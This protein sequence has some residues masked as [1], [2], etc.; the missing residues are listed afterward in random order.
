MKMKKMLV[1]AV[2]TA[3]AAV[4]ICATS[5]FAD[6]PTQWTYTYEDAVKPSMTSGMYVTNKNG[7]TPLSGRYFLHAMIPPKAAGTDGIVGNQ[8][9]IS[10]PMKLE[11]GKEYKLSFWY[12]ETGNGNPYWNNVRIA[13]KNNVANR[14][15]GENNFYNGGES[16][17]WA[18]KK[19]GDTTWTK[20]E[21]TF[22]YDSSKTEEPCIYFLFRATYNESGVAEYFIDDCS[23]V[24]KDDPT[25]TNLLPNG[26]FETPSWEGAWSAYS[27]NGKH[28]ED[29]NL[30]VNSD[31]NYVSKGQKSIYFKYPGAY[32]N[33]DE[34]VLY[35]EKPISL[36]KD[37]T[38]TLSFYIASNDS[39]E[40]NFGAS[41][42][43]FNGARL[44]KID[45]CF[46]WSTYKAGYTG[47]DQIPE[48]AFLWKQQD[49]ET[50]GTNYVKYT[51]TPKDNFDDLH[52]CIELIRSAWGTGRP[53]A[54]QNLYI[55][56]VR[57]AET[58]S[59]LNMLDDGSFEE[60]PGSDY[61][62]YQYIGT[63]EGSKIELVEAKDDGSK[64]WGEN[65]KILRMEYP[66][67]GTGKMRVWSKPIQ[68]LEDGKTYTLTFDYDENGGNNHWDYETVGLMN[69][70]DTLPLVPKY[71][72]GPEGRPVAQGSIQA[73]RQFQYSNGWTFTYHKLS[74]DAPRIYYE[75]SGPSWD[76]ATVVYLDNF[77]LCEEG[78]TKNLIKD[79][80]FEG[81]VGKVEAYDA[82]ISG[83]GVSE[84][85][86]T[87]KG[88]VTVSAKASNSTAQSK[89]VTVIAA[90][91]HGDKLIDVS[92]HTETVNALEDDKTI[93]TDI[94]ISELDDSSEYVL[95]CFVWDSVDGMKP[96]MNEVAI[97]DVFRK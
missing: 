23:V 95:K 90:Y 7:V 41:F 48:G 70:N 35:S 91:Y 24:A 83:A 13:D 81:V 96:I 39:P 4:G 58:D 56:D 27:S 52:L 6:F 64:P 89:K 14:V 51:I 15:W 30:S 73:I 53:G 38:Y 19:V 68:G 63:T 12:I 78:S 17:G 3:L 71:T 57:L 47:S 67:N 94:N 60:N 28:N 10:E 80:D 45:A 42:R 2:T 72:Y 21:Y 11:N 66:A 65:N 32:Q 93:S 44:E 9:A 82:S 33:S 18:T 34:L 92:E 22:T 59:D 86:I 26:D 69:E 36:K 75:V 84:G 31:T 29:L 43:R 76:R 16:A 20:C 97:F 61:W 87:A 55:D 5:A 74:D 54:D 37:K 1:T 25:E 88:N 49:Y 79:G 50:L 77:R 85:V 40:Q 62:N 8:Y 46:E